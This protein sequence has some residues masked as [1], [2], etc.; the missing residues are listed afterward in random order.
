[1]V[2]RQCGCK[3]TTGQCGLWSKL[4]FCKSSF[5]GHFIKM[6]TNQFYKTLEIKITQSLSS[7]PRMRESC[8]QFVSFMIGRKTSIMFCQD[9]E[10]QR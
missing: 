4:N 3:C 1:M 10:I 2:Q 8:I 7:L 9:G 6:Q 5:S